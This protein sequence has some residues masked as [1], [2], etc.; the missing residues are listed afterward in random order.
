MS[1]ESSRHSSTS[2]LKS[3]EDP[4][5]PAQSTKSDVITTGFSSNQ[6]S[7]ITL[8]PSPTGSLEERQGEVG[9]ASVRRQ[10]REQDSDKE[11]DSESS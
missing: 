5:I 2:S 1:R 10:V 9:V 8:S 6:P 11:S 3:G 7:V 4:S